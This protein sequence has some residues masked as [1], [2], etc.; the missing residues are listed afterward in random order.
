MNCVH[1]AEATVPDSSFAV[2]ESLLMQPNGCVRMFVLSLWAV[3]QPT[4]HEAY[5]CG[6]LSSPHFMKHMMSAGRC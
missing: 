4:F 5:V 3:V 2:V 6:P 1:N